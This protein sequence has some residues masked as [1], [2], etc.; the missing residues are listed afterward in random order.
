MESKSHGGGYRN[1]PRHS[2]FRKGTSG[3]PSGRPKGSCDIGKIYDRVLSR[4]VQLHA[5]GRRKF[6][7]VIEAIALR[8]AGLALKGDVPAIRL[9]LQMAEWAENR[10]VANEERESHLTVVLES[11]LSKL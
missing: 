9:V 4:R 11:E 6:G 7:T 1:P 10:A 3:N 8:V 2:Q 5:T